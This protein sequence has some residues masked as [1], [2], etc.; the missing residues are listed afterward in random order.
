MHHKNK[1][2]TTFRFCY[3]LFFCTFFWRKKMS[4]PNQKI[5]TIH[6]SDQIPFLKIGIEELME[7]Y[8]TIKTPSSFVLYLYLA[9]ARS[10]V[11]IPQLS[12]GSPLCWHQAGP[13]PWQRGSQQMTLTSL[14]EC[15][16]PQNSSHTLEGAKEGHPALHS[17]DPLPSLPDFVSDI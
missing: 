9:P 2:F 1:V 10:R 11:F 15:P 17:P 4:V 7:A 5:I 13:C 12:L 6:Q 16:L 3:L 14:L 8:R